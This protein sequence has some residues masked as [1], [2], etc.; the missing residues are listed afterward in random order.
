M[1]LRVTPAALQ[2][3]K[4]IKEYISITLC[5]PAAAKR[6]VSNIISAYKKLTDSPF[7]GTSLRAKVDIDTPFRYLVSGNYLIF[8][9]TNDDHVDIH[10]IIYGK[11]DY[12]RILFDF[13]TNDDE[14]TEETAD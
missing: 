3:M 1:K 7:I 9:Q 10:R 8:Y 5:N 13:E 6:T 2:D 12:I 4:D 14:S 11:R